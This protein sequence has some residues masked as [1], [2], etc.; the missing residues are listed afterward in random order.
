M[1]IKKIFVFVIWILFFWV[2]F[3]EYYEANSEIKS[4]L[5]DLTTS[6]QNIEQYSQLW[7]EVPSKYFQNIAN[8]FSVLKNKLPQDN[9]SFKIVYGKCEISASDLVNWYSKSKLNTFKSQ[10]FWPWKTISRSIF[11]KYQ[12][13]SRIKANPNSWNAPLTVTFDWR[14]SK[15]PSNRTVPTNNYYWYYT[16]SEGQ[17]IFMGQWSLIKYTFN[18]PNNYVVHLTTKSANKFTK[19][20]LDGE[21]ITTISVNPSIAKVNLYINWIRAI[22][23]SYVKISSQEWK[24]WVLFDAS[25]TTPN[26]VTKIVASSWNIQYNWKTIFTKN[27]PDFPGSIRVKL[28]QKWF[29]FITLKL[30]DNTWKTISKTFKLI[31]SNPVS[32]IKISTKS[33]NT[34]T[35]F[36]IDGSASYSVNWNIEKYSWTIVDPNGNKIDSFQ[37]KK[38]FNYKFKKPWYYSIKLE[39]EDVNWNK[40]DATYK[41]EVFSTPPV[42]NFVY[43]KY[44]SWEKPSTFIFDGSLSSDV[45][46]IN[47]DKLT[48]TWNITNRNNIK[49]QQINHWQKILAQFNKRWTYNVTLLV[50]DKYWKTSQITKKLKIASVLRPKVSLNP[51]YTILWNSIGIKLETNKPVL[52]YKYSY[53]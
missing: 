22:D 27:I 7:N 29:Y 42:A 17:R 11:T 21:D 1:I 28:N 23:A 9:P 20:I 50:K 52:Y 15:D 48:Y 10:C 25:W 51:N 39:V 35:N 6:F 12:V 49:I 24:A 32:L 36:N 33:G 37:W 2:S 46:M 3:W 47:W 13:Q 34:S 26:W 38:N 44:D 14:S 31:V 5:D 53:W 19:W 16:N 40:N 45:D 30:R 18:T 8:D 41:L 43:K 4:Y